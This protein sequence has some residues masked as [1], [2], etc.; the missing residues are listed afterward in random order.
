[1]F[2]SPQTPMRGKTF[3]KM[4]SSSNDFI[5][6]RA[7][8][9]GNLPARRMMKPKANAPTYKA[10]TSQSNGSGIRKAK[11][12][13]VAPQKQAGPQFNKKRIMKVTVGP[14]QKGIKV[15]AKS[16]EAMSKGPYK[17]RTLGE[18]EF[19][20]YLQKKGVLSA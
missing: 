6:K 14:V 8:E 3:G 5:I 17:Q 19:G 20:Q 4:K 10:A 18:Q 7:H 16:P 12:I 9:I 15:V 11:G 1:M 13:P 2:K